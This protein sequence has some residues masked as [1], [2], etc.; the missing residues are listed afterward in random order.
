[1]AHASFPGQVQRQEPSGQSNGERKFSPSQ[2]F[3][4]AQAFGDL[5]AVSYWEGPSSLLS[6]RIQIA[7]HQKHIHRPISNHVKP[8]IWVSHGSVWLTYNLPSQSRQ[9]GQPSHVNYTKGV[10]RR[11]QSTHEKALTGPQKWKGSVHCWR[12]MMNKTENNMKKKLYDVQDLDCPVYSKSH[13][14]IKS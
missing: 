7:I 14:G 9:M 10:L 11:H 8:N 5:N 12:P 1:M 6:K 13:K 3:C 2:P 4:S